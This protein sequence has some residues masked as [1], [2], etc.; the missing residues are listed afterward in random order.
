MDHGEWRTLVR[1]IDPHDI[2][3]ITL[4]MSADFGQVCLYELLQRELKRGFFH[5]SIF[6]GVQANMAEDVDDGNT[7]TSSPCPKYC[8]HIFEIDQHAKVT[9]LDAQITNH[10]PLL[11]DAELVPTIGTNNK[12]DTLKVR[13]PRPAANTTTTT[14]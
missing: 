5:E 4:N 14:P 8:V 12:C 9:D 13:A 11:V 3:T 2:K 10:V 6:V 1:V 7:R